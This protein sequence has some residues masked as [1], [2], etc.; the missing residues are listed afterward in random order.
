MPSIL[1][2]NLGTKK[3]KGEE[4]EE[5]KRNFTDVLPGF[6]YKHHQ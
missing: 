6:T 4:E 1:G 5:E 3:R 2:S